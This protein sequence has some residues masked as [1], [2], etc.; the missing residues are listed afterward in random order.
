MTK[1]SELQTI[2]SILLTIAAL[3]S[4]AV[5]AGG[6]NTSQSPSRQVSDLQIT[7]QVKS[8]LASDVRPSSLANID[9][10]TTNGVVTLAGQVESAD[11]KRNAETVAASVPGVVRVNN[12]LQVDPSAASVAH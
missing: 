1:K 2:F 10:N 9:V 11:V 6:C 12:N 8:K 7:T 3:G 5:L 4:L